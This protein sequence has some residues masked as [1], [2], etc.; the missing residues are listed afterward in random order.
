MVISING[1]QEYWYEHALILK[2]DLSGY[3]MFEHMI[4]AD[5]DTTSNALIDWFTTFGAGQT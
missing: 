5:S 4:E 2:D 3:V 1:M